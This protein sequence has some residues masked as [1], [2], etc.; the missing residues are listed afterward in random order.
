MC[1]I[2]AAERVIYKVNDVN[3]SFSEMMALAEQPAGHHLLAALVQQ[4]RSGYPTQVRRTLKNI[5][6]VLQSKTAQL[7]PGQ[8]FDLIQA[9]E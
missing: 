5:F 4:R 8:S 6:S 9:Y 7:T 1:N 2:V 3:T